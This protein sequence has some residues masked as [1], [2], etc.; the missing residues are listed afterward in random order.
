MKVALIVV[1]IVALAL[2]SATFYFFQSNNHAQNELVAL[3]TAKDELAG[4][5]QILQDEKAAKPR[6]RKLPRSREPTK[7]WSPT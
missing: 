5:V 1:S 6:K 7:R 3:R 4:Q 2:A